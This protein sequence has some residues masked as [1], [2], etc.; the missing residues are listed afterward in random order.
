MPLQASRVLKTFKYAMYF[1]GVNSEVK[2]PASM[3]RNVLVDRATFMFWVNCFD[4][5]TYRRVFQVDSYYFV[6]NLETLV[7]SSRLMRLALGNPTAG[8]IA[9]F[10]DKPV[11]LGAFFH[12]TAWFE[13]PTM[14]M[15]INGVQQSQTATYNGSLYWGEATFIWIGVGY[16]YYWLGLISQALSYSRALSDY[17]IQWNYLYPD[18]PVRDG[19]VLWLQADPDYIKDI[20][21]DGVLEWIDLSGFGN[22]GKIYGASLVQLV[23]PASR[24]LPKARILNVLR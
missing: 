5:S 2:V 20:D 15:Y 22:H 14:K 4:A 21:G 16:I 1:N 13:R 19:L 18:N 8:Q 24:I 6:L 17:E 11:S 9:I 12:V 10:S 7:G 3:L 23:K